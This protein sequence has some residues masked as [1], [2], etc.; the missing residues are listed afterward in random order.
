[1]QLLRLNRAV[2]GAFA[3]L[4]AAVFA[5]TPRPLAD[6]PIPM[7]AGKPIN[8]KQYRG[9]V[10]LMAVMSLDCDTCI[11]SVDILNR[12]QKEFGPRGF[13]VV[14]AVGDPSAQ[15]LL[16]GFSQRYRP[17]FPIGYLNQ[18]Q[19]IQLADLGKDAQ[20]AYVPIFMFIDRKGTVRHQASGNEPFFKNE[21]FLTRQTVQDML[22]P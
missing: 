12:L 6:V 11:K 7:P 13:Q 20:H 16:G 8:L 19:I 4:S 1:M 21:E 2:L 15:Y 22:K 3:L 5:A 18:A 17:I 9:K 10:V 14:A